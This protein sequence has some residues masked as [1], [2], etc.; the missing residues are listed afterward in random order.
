[1]SDNSLSTSSSGGSSNSWTILTPESSAAGVENVG[2][3]DDG[4]R[5]LAN[6]PSLSQDTTG[7]LTESDVS[8]KDAPV[9][10]LRS[11]EGLQVCQE[12]VAECDQGF[13]PPSP[14]LL[15]PSPTSHVP[16]LSSLESYSSAGTESDSHVGSSLQTG[17]Q[18]PVSPAVDTYADACTHISPPGSS[19]PVGP[20]PES[21]ISVH[22]LVTE[23]DESWPKEQPELAKKVAEVGKQAVQ[24]LDHLV[25]DLFQVWERR[26]RRLR[27]S[28]SPFDSELGEV[29]ATEGDHLRQ[30]KVRPLGPLDTA[31]KQADEDEDEEEEY[32]PILR[33]E[34]RGGFSLNK[35]ILGALIL[36]GLGTILFSGEEDVEVRD[37]KDPGVPLSQ[38]WLNQDMEATRVQEMAELLDKLTQENQQITVLQAQLQA[39]TEELNLALQ[40]AE[41]GGKDLVRKEELEKE[42]ERMRLELSSLPN[43]QRELETLRARVTELTQ[44]TANNDAM[45][46]PATTSV[47]P[48][49]GQND[50]S[51]QTT[52][53]EKA[54]NM[55]EGENHQ[56]DR[57][58]E[59]LERQK[60]LL[61]ES[62]KRLEGMKVESG[63][64]KGVR[65][66]LVEVERRLS[67]E[68]ARLGRRREAMRKEGH[69]GKKLEGQGDRNREKKWGREERKGWKEGRDLKR[70]RDDWG[71]DGNEWQ[72]REER[73]EWKMSREGRRNPERQWEDKAERREWKEKRDW[74]KGHDG[75]RE[76][77][78]E[79]K[80]R[81]ESKEWRGD[82]EWKHVGSG[83]RDKL[84]KEKN[85][86][87]E[88]EEK[89]K[90]WSQDGDTRRD[91]WKEVMKNGEWK[92]SEEH[93]RGREWPKDDEKHAGHGGE[94]QFKDH[95]KKERH[96]KSTVDKKPLDVTH[97]HHEHND[98][99]KGKKQKLQ[100]YY[101]P[102]ANCSDVTECA[103][104]EGLV[105][106]QLADFE[107]L[108]V[109]YLAKLGDGEAE[110]RSK[111][112]IGSLVR[113]FFVD[114]VFRHDRILFRDFVEDLA[115]ILEDIVETGGNDELE[116]EMEQFE[117]EALQK[118]V[119]EG[120]EE[121]RG[122]WKRG[123]GRV[124]A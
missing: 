116:E 86:R 107:G 79:G 26:L 31:E 92:S 24:F 18:T 59:E 110:A 93:H 97:R 8:S 61:Q 41:Q 81:V 96:W 6:T 4:S 20:S 118:F 14:T 89:R 62:R 11:E 102:P 71:S 39:Q 113:D 57:L 103:E 88:W 120:G 52:G 75:E 105:P 15:S 85:D 98:Y 64:K 66:G 37:L 73:K 72:E 74:K 3:V 63:G 69:G 23:E 17:G 54:A 121:N 122:D 25:T 19:I 9:D 33:E 50:S 101:R 49:S 35:C 119:L 36:L 10:G 55:E 51:S 82:K 90:E 95:G 12:T 112:E 80:E 114:G 70:G 77:R 78:N 65:D 83:E 40:R 67:E 56:R 42:N 21:S 53:D 117:A 1:M 115:D 7:S 32:R 47:S 58:T 76:N 2:P 109:G 124:R 111:E 106:V 60:V 27:V 34:E 22:A 29:R 44:I 91:G 13:T 87:K 16:L 104:L 123:N 30:R 94:R 5:S 48:S 46:S 108:L 68:V 43:L 100:H 45:Q 99:W 28:D 38:D 84:W